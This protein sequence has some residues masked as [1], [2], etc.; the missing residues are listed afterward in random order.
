[1]KADNGR[2]PMRVPVDYPIT[3]DPQHEY[4][5]GCELAY[6][7]Y[8]DRISEREAFAQRALLAEPIIVDVPRAETR[9]TTPTKS[10]T[11]LAQTLLS[12]GFGSRSAHRAADP[13]Y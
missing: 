4:F 11:D 5:S 12:Q 7:V 1:M 13:S 9:K 3:D 8:L 2:T 10:I 6:A